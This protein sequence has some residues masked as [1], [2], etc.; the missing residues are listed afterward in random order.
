[1]SLRF[2]VC[3]SQARLCLKRQMQSVRSTAFRRHPAQ[4]PAKAGTTNNSQVCFET[5][6][7][8]NGRPP[9]AVVP[10]TFLVFD[11]VWDK[12]GYV[13]KLTSHSMTARWVQRWKFSYLVFDS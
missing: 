7:G 6:P 12:R 11:H 8:I 9:I 1:M 4:L 10:D 2:S 5:K 13:K 3:D